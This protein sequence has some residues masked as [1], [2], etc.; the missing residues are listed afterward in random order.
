M[1]KGTKSKTYG[2]SI[3]G[4]ASY[5]PAV[6]ATDEGDYVDLVIETGNPHSQSGTALRVD[7][8]DGDTIGYVPEDN[9]LYRAVVTERKGGLARVD[10]K[11]GKPLGIRLEVQLGDEPIPTAPYGE[12]LPQPASKGCLGSVA[13]L[14]AL[15]CYPVLERL[16]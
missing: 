13:A 7:N 11:G 10:F 5:Q 14:L 6:R 16:V 9:W 12:R 2:V 3:V 8:M 1:A 15:T 4:E